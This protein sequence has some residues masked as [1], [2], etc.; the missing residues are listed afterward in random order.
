MYARNVTKLPLA[1]QFLSYRPIRRESSIPSDRT[2]R[3][4]A[5]PGGPAATGPQRGNQGGVSRANLS[6][7]CKNIRRCVFTDPSSS[8]ADCSGCGFPG[9]PLE[10]ELRKRLGCFGRSWERNIACDPQPVIHI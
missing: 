4:P 5:V 7:A 2:N 8:A 9:Q 3:N 6:G 1:Y 10:P